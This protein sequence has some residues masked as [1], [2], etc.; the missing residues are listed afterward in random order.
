MS[1]LIKVPVVIAVFL[2]SGSE[3][4]MSFNVHLADFFV[5]N[6][7]NLSSQNIFNRFGTRSDTGYTKLELT[8]LSLVGP[9]VSSGETLSQRLSNVRSILA[10][11]NIIKFVCKSL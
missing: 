11:L 8:T 9:V 1:C 2:F 7:T 3:I 4:A 10:L 5:F 6:H